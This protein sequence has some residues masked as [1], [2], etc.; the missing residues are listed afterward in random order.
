MTHKHARQMLKQQATTIKR[1]EFPY[2]EEEEDVR[3]ASQMSLASF[4]E[5]TGR[6]KSSRRTN[7]IKINRLPEELQPDYR[8]PPYERAMRE[9][10]IEI[11]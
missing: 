7:I 4:A 8:I 11:F 9:A 6:T 2:E 5:P 3:Q 1:E 10:H